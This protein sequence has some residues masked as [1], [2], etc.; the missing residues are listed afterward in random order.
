L[1]TDQQQFKLGVMLGRLS[2]KYNQ[3][4]QSFPLN[5]WKEEFFNAKNLNLDCIEWVEDG[6][7]DFCNPLFSAIGR[8]DLLKLQ[9]TH[10]ISIDSICCHSFVSGG[11]ISP[12]QSIRHLW[13]ERLNTIL[14]WA[15][16]INASSIILPVMEGFAIKNLID[17][18][19]FLDSM[20]QINFTVSD[21]KILIETDLEAEKVFQLTQMLNTDHFGVVYDLGNAAQLQFNI[22]DDIE[23]LCNV[24]D[25]I[26]FKDKDE[27]GSNRLGNGN[28]NFDDA[29]KAL[30]I[31]NW[32]GR[33][34]LETPIFNNWE[35]EAHHNVEFAKNFI[36]SIK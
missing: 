30:K 20:K 14:R 34:I 33:F 29:I 28:T 19:L 4:L 26:H 1:I 5:T 21:V 18:K 13:I 36:T 2:A 35:L 23:L 16:E 9:H 10:S 12:D 27:N 25:E 15:S 7:S 6:N 32:M 17:E 11:L 22:Y 31:C 24:I 3:P 8:E